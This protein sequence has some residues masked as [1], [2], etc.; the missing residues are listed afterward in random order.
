MKQDSKTTNYDILE[1]ERDVNLN[2]RKIFH[3]VFRN[4]HYHLFNL[5]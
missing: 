3:D 5:P 2:Y 1:T 4:Y